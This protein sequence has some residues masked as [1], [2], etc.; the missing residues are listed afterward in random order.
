ML[1]LGNII[2]QIMNDDD[3]TM[4]KNGC[5]ILAPSSSPSISPTDTVI[6]S[7][8]PTSKPSSSVFRHI[9]LFVMM[10][11]YLLRLTL[12]I[13]IVPKY[14]QAFA[15]SQGKVQMQSQLQ[16]LIVFAEEVFFNPHPQSSSIYCLTY[17]GGSNSST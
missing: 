9:L 3:V 2:I 8:S 15:V 6:P 5:P 17:L 12:K 11:L 7:F 1:S 16:R 4:M 10:I 13:S 14:V